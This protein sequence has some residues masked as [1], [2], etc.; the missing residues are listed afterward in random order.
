MSKHARHRKE[1]RRNRLSPAVTLAAGLAFL[2]PLAGVTAAQAAPADIQNI[3]NEEHSEY[4]QRILN[5]INKYRASLGLKP[6]KYSPVVSSFSQEKSDQMIKA[7]DF[8]HDKDF[9]NDSRI[10]GYK[11]ANEIIALQYSLSPEGLVEWWKTS[12]SHNAAMINPNHDTIGIGVTVTDGKLDNTGKPWK[13]LA[14]AH[15]YKYDNAAPTQIPEFLTSPGN[16]EYIQYPQDWK[17]SD[18]FRYAKGA[19]ADRE[20]SVGTQSVDS[21]EKPVDAEKELLKWAVDQDLIQL[22]DKELSLEGKATR[23]DWAKFLYRM[24]GEPDV[25]QEDHGTSDLKKG[26]DAEMVWA[27]KEGLLELNKEKESRPDDKLTKDELVKS[28]W[29]SSG[30][31]TKDYKQEWYAPYKDIDW[32]HPLYNKVSWTHELG[33][34][35]VIGDKDDAYKGKSNVSKADLIKVMK[36]TEDSTKISWNKV[37][38]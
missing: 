38:K 12:K 15:L 11:Q 4:S 10:Q 16:T 13:I 23:E 8:W 14:V 18:P 32:K 31:N 5:A 37:S 21:T 19:T 26:K 29:K 36:M 3:S 25:S 24:N 27:V 6:V 34:N 35:D 22:S 9:L 2:S 33:L 17:D 20:F 30:T 7:E 1:T 28:I